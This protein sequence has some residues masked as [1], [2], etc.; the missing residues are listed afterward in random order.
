[1]KD[2]LATITLAAVDPVHGRNLTREYLQA[3]I[4]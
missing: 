2:Y 1:M 4:Q 3:R